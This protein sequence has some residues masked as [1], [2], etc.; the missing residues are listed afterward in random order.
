MTQD[1]PLTAF[2]IEAGIALAQASPSHSSPVDLESPAWEGVTD[3]TLVKALTTHPATGLRDAEDQ[4]IAGG[5]RLLFVVGEGSTL[6]GLVTSTD[7]HGDHQVTLVSERGIHYD[8]LIVADVMTPLARLDAVDFDELRDATVGDL[9]A[10]MRHF[11]RN[12]MLVVQSATHATPRRMRAVISRSQ[13]ERQLG[14]PIDITPIARS[15]AE[16]EQALHEA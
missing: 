7:L 10:T 14:I 13:I 8:D 12:H 9:V 11:G 3:L 1:T 4:M 16:I 15:F 2:H 6:V 5:V